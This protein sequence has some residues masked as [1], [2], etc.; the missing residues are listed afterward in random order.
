MMPAPCHT[1]CEGLIVFPAGPGSTP[2][3]SGPLL[4]EK[5]GGNSCVAARWYMA[6]SE[7]ADEAELEDAFDGFSP[8]AAA[9]EDGGGPRLGRGMRSRFKPDLLIGAALNKKCCDA[10]N[11]TCRCVSPRC[12][13]SVPA[14]FSPEEVSCWS[15]GVLFGRAGAS[16]RAAANSLQPTII[17]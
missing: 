10:Y 17:S 4:Q 15:E 13:A 11:A 2:P 5:G 12:R 7:R 9:E 3:T 1:P 16:K 8:P 14:P 6:A